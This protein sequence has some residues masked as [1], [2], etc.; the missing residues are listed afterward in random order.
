MMMRGRY[1]GVRSTALLAMMLACA[2]HGAAADADY[3]RK[4][5]RIVVPY[6]PGG[7]IDFIARMIAQGINGPLGQQVIVDN[8]PGGSTVIGADAVAKAAPDGYTLLVTS[9]STHA[10]LPNT[11]RKL[12]FDADRDFAPVS[13]LVSQPFVLVVHPSLPA[14]NVQQLIAI[15]K[16]RPGDLTYSSSG[17]GTGTHLSGEL[18]G[19]LA[20]IEIRHIPYKG[21][22]QS[23]TELAGGHVSMS[24][25]SMP[26]ALP[27]VKAGKVRMIAVTGLKRSLAA[28]ELATIAESGVPGYQFTAWSA[29]HVPGG[30]AKP[31]IDIL[32]REV[33][34]LLNRPDV[35]ERLM[36]LGYDIEASTPYELRDYIGKERATYAK[37]MRMT[38][39]DKP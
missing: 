7:G 36:P 1:A 8:R 17:I 30:T 25:G 12:P 20:K 38:G 6:T 19:A 3:P 28:P 14:R 24:F 22:A 18:L 21:G 23:F 5:L 39:L 2:P 37:L 16:K 9:H 11:G 15:A 35:K 27:Y 10:F 4:P 13:L 34:K 31:I 29:L 32:N 26:S 33:V